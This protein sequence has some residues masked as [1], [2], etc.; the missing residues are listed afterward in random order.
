MDDPSVPLPAPLPPTL[1]QRY[2]QLFRFYDRQ[3]DGELNLDS[4][5]R[6]A[7][8]GAQPPSRICSGC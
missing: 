3:G 8:R 1:V 5:F 2:R 4:D 7:G 6:P